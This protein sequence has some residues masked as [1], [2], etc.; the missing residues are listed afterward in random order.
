M[1]NPEKGKGYDEYTSLH[2]KYWHD[3]YQYHRYNSQYYTV[4]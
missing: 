3:D 1:E 2:C 4:H